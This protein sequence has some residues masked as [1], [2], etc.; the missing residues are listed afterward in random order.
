MKKGNGLNIEDLSING[1]QFSNAH[2]VLGPKEIKL[3]FVSNRSGGMG[4]TD[5]YSVDIFE[6]GKL[7]EPINLGA[8]SKHQRKRVFPVC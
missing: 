6:S 8:R 7:G 3:Y 5:I 4:Q 2:P 1:E